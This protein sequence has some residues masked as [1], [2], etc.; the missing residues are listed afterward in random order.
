MNTKTTQKSMVF[1]YTSNE[2]T[3]KEIREM[4][5]FKTA[6]RKTKCLGTSLTKEVKDLSRRTTQIASKLSGI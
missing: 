6:S 2:F 3:I 1:L 4:I 5:V